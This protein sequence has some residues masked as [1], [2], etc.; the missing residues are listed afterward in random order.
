MRFDGYF[1]IDKYFMIHQFKMLLYNYKQK[2]GQPRGAHALQNYLVSLTVGESS[3]MR[4]YMSATIT[5][6]RAASCYQKSNF[7]LVAR[8]L[9]TRT[10]GETGDNS[11]T[12][13]S[14][15]LNFFFLPLKVRG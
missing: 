11:T 2:S 4:S 14:V 5:C 13:S 6:K 7:L 8:D 3:R 1:T 12:S 9:V 10:G 15:L